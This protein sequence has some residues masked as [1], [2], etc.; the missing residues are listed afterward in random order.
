MKKA[1]M[2][3]ALAACVAGGFVAGR[4]YLGGTNEMNAPSADVSNDALEKAQKR[5]T[6]LETELAE[7]K[8]E[9]ERVQKLVDRA[10]KTVSKVSKAIKG[11]DG[12]GEMTLTVD[13]EEDMIAE[14]KKQLPEEAFVAAT[15]VLGRLKAAQAERVKGRREYLASLDVSGLS[16]KEQENHGKFMELFDRRETAMSKMK[17][18]IPDENTIKELVEIEMQMQPL[19]KQERKALLGALTRELGY[20]GDDGEVVVDTIESIFDCSGS[21]G[22]LGGLGD[23]GDMLNGAEIQPSVNVK[24]QVIS[25]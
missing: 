24:T 23:L 3:L 15:N 19:A 14:M 11:K 18:F 4:K 22:G 8:K 13:N 9:L 6:E 20:A 5:V 7:T 25:L 2:V 12:E 21:S 17:G 1:I 10:E 16:A